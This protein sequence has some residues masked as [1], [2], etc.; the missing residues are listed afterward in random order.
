MSPKLFAKDSVQTLAEFEQQALCVADVLREQGIQAGSRVL[1]KASNSAAYVSTLLAL[2]H[3]GASIVLLDYQENAEQTTA[4]ARR[5]SAKFVL[6]SD[7]A[8]IAED[9]TPVFLYELLVAAGGRR[10]S[11]ERLCFDT[12]C[13]LPD[14]LIMWSSGSTGTPKG[15]VKNG[16]NFLRNLERNA[17][18]VG[19]TS[20]DALL[21]LLPFSHQYGLS[22]VLIAWLVRCSLII[23]P[24]RRI[25]HALHMGLQCGATVIDATP[26][27]YR[28]IHNIVRKRT[29]L[30]ERLRSVRMFC[31]G[32]APLDQPLSDTYVEMFG[33]PLL[34]SYGSTELGN[35]AFATLDNPVGCGKVMEG[36]DLRIVGED[37]DPNNPLPPNELGE[38]VVLCPDMMEGILDENGELDVADR[39]WY[40]TNDL[41]YLT[42]DGNLFV[43]GRKYAVNRKGYTLYPELLERKVAAAGCSARIVALPDERQG[44]QLIFFVEDDLG[45]DAR[46]WRDV[47]DGV[48]PVY[49]QPNRV[50]V[51]ANFPLNRN[52]KP[53]KKA[54]EKLAAQQ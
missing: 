38:I 16:G 45:R 26:A 42:E 1:F 10:P 18:Q 35:V 30:R 41:G 39:G 11:D 8:P 46:Y 53:D 43:S 32:A 5:A 17:K 31:V 4:I 44:S 7:D 15:V 19:H 27:T 40:H 23:A 52:G 24:Y 25:D 21:P 2:M 36:L 14:G 28:S 48:L 50:E 9:E 12:W 37:G 51:L 49:E 34:D 3:V 47:I 22:M 33:L 54:L 13:E 29:G 20:S 6:V